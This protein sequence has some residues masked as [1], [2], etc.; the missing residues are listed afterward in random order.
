MLL[1]SNAVMKAG[2][3]HLRRLNNVDQ[4]QEPTYPK[5][6][7][8]NPGCHIIGVIEM[9]NFHI[10]STKIAM[11][12]KIRMTHESIFSFPSSFERVKIDILLSVLPY[13]CEILG[14]NHDVMIDSNMKRL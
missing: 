8:S 9:C 13:N 3:E 5:Q 6:F 10:F 11:R 1:S 7:C 4:F 12:T 2:N 14:N